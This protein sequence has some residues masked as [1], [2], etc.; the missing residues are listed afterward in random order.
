[1]RNGIGK[2]RLIIPRN[3]QRPPVTHDHILRPNRAKRINLQASRRAIDPKHFTL[4]VLLAVCSRT[5]RVV[6]IKEAVQAR[7][8]DHR[9]ARV[10]QPQTQ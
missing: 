4:A 5:P 8:V 6:V 2:R 10:Q 3:S 9:V 7:T 1:M